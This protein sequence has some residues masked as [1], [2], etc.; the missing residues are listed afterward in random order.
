MLATQLM[1]RVCEALQVELPLRRFFENPTIAGL[2]V[3]VTQW[4]TEQL[5]SEAAASIVAELEALSPAEV[6]SRLANEARARVSQPHWPR[7]LPLPPHRPSRSRRPLN[8]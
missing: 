2:A 4:Q 6:Q 8:P 3:A 5:A 7:F 1:A